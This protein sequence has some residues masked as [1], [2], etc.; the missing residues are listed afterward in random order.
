MCSIL[1]VNISRSSLKAITGS[2]LGVISALYPLEAT[3]PNIG[4]GFVLMGMPLNKIACSLTVVS[5][6]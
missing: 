5:R 4:I 2:S 3:V 1:S 6:I